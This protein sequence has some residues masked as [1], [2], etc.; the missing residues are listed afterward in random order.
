[1]N[2]L[3][4]NNSISIDI[5]EATGTAFFGAKVVFYKL[6]NLTVKLTLVS[7]MQMQVLH[8]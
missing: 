6:A 8:F 3:E 4:I 7:T 2:Q 1:V 5:H